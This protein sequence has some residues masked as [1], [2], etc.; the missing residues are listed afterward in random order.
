MNIAYFA[1]CFCAICSDVQIATHKSWQ[2]CS[3]FNWNL[4]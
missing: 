1:K 3:D 2:V 4:F